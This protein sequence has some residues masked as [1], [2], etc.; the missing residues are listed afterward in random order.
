MTIIIIMLMTLMKT[1]CYMK[2]SLTCSHHTHVSLT[3]SLTDEIKVFITL[4]APIGVYFKKN[5]LK[6]YF[7][8]KH[9]FKKK[10]C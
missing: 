5:K 9:Y 10:T 1:P 3:H 2:L 8:A 7:D 6:D 4:R